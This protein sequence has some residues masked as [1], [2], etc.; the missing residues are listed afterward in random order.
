VLISIWIATYRLDAWRR[1]HVGKS[2]IELAEGKLALFYQ[3]V[4]TVKDLRH[5]VGFGAEHDEIERGDGETER[6]F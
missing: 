4:E 2:Q 6:A 3:A 1:E 5:P